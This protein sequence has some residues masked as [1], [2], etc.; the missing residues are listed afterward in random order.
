[1]PIKDIEIY[2]IAIDLPNAP[3][4]FAISVLV[5]GT[6]KDKCIEDYEI[7]YDMMPYVFDRYPIY[8][9]GDTISIEIKQ[10]VTVSSVVSVVEC[11]IASP[12]YI[13]MIFLGY[14]KPGEY[15]IDVNGYTETFSVA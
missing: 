13:D 6:L 5:T 12:Y 4:V 14:C 8:S 3:D 1:M 15:T 7:D 10:T 2:T 9:D 11:S